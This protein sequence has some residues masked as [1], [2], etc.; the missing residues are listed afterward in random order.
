[1]FASYFLFFFSALGTFNGLALSSYLLW[2]QPRTPAQRWLAALVLMLSVRTGKSV[3]YFFWPSIPKL[4]LQFGLS[5]CF[6]IGPCLVGFVRAW[7]DPAGQQT[8][9]DHWIALALLCLVTVL[10]ALFPYSE[11]VSL[12]RG[13][14]WQFIQYWWLF[15]L[16]FSG[17]LL[18][19][20]GGLPAGQS[21]WKG[22]WFGRAVALGVGLVWLAFFTAGLTSYIVGALSFSV[23]LFLG[24]AI[25]LTRT[26]ET[27]ANG[28]KAAPYQQR[29]IPLV[30]A[31][32]ELQ[33]LNDLMSREK[34]YKDPSLTLA[35]VARRLGIPD[36]RL[37]QLLND[38]Q[39]VS[40]K[41]Y[42]SQWRVEAA[43]TL[44]KEHASMSMEQVAEEAGFLSMSTFYSTFKKAENL[45]PAAW[46]QGLQTGVSDS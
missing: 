3:L 1:M 10:G 28:I 9:H 42:L 18:Y 6:L 25:A 7:L 33:A 5:A 40:F 20:A 15:C 19:R 36:A 38:N 43:K 29:K 2:C 41:Q 34:L 30:E 21:P 39:K 13:P 37:S 24:I 17:Y 11:H 35:K 46:R 14:V 22:P 26:Q 16:V 44:L 27:D 45:T 23:V 8:R 12:W 31:Q 32:A 4:A